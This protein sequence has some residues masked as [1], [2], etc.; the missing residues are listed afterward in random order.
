M[1]DLTYDTE[2][3]IAALATPWGEAPLA[4]IRTT[5]SGSIGKIASIFSNGKT[6]LDAPGST[7]H[8]GYLVDPDSKNKIDQV[9]TAVYKAPLSYTGQDSIEIFCHGGRPGIQGILELLKKAGFRSAGP[10]EFTLRAFLNKKVDLTRAE[11]V[12]EIVT[13]KSRRAHS[14]ALHRLSGTI[15][16]N[17]DKIK[18]NLLELMSS[19]EL[20]LDYPDDEV[21]DIYSLSVNKIEESEKDIQKMLNTYQTGIIYKEGVRVTLAGRTN[22]GK[23][24]LFNLFLK[25]D[26]SIVSEIHGTTRDYIES[27]IS[28]D[29][30]PV[31]LYDTAGLREA[32]HSVEAEGIKR[33]NNIIN[34]SRLIIY[35]IDAQV[36][37]SSEDKDFIKYYKQKCIV[38]WNKIDLTDNICPEG[39]I[40]LS[41]ETGDGFLLLENRI[42]EMIFFG[43]DQESSVVIDSLRQKELLEKCNESLMFVKTGI[44]EGI[45]LD[46]LSVDLKDAIDALGEITG[47]VTSADILNT[48]FSKFCVGK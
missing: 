4:V 48:M 22:A 36:G 46:A 3:C 17:I 42:K 2:D 31:T 18:R 10:G 43:H 38:I 13:S 5:G 34:N 45:S 25:E 1:N 23:S 7:I 39:F 28:I 24:S 8:L 44:T 33:S 15:E 47:E 35:I 21:P 37:L 11:A 41:A 30:I 19:I 20:Q 32:E 6:I 16:N 9:M 40:P 29:G 26:R 12:Q 27:W 14:L